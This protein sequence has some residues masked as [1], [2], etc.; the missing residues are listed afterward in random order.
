MMAGPPAPMELLMK[1]TSLE[2]GQPV[3]LP[4]LKA[5]SSNGI[6]DLDLSV[7]LKG[8]RVIVFGVPG[9]FT[10]LC[11]EKHVPSFMSHA[12]SFHQKGID[13]VVCVSV[14]DP[15]VLAAWKRTLGADDSILFVA[16]GNGTWVKSMG[17]TFD[18]S[19]FG[20]GERAKRFAM[21]LDDGILKMLEVEETPGTC[22][23][24][25][26]ESFLN[27]VRD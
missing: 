7:F 13:H 18:G 22:G 26:G 2:V 9:A 12:S 27:T 25:S 17:L 21:L 4:H 11:S 23:A 8:K 20:L 3:P 14:N 1:Q 10:P 15:F 24:T 16:D 5:V 6:Q 19:A